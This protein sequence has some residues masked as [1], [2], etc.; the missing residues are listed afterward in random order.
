MNPKR[1][2]HIFRDCSGLQKTGEEKFRQYKI[3]KAD[4]KVL[5]LSWCQLSKSERSV[6]GVTEM[7]SS[8]LHNCSPCKLG[9]L[10]LWSQCQL[11][12]WK[13]CYN[14]KKNRPH[15]MGQSVSRSFPGRV[16]IENAEWAFLSQL[17]L[18]NWMALG[19]VPTFV[20][21]NLPVNGRYISILCTIQKKKTQ[22]TVVFTKYIDRKTAQFQRC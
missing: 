6:Q 3:L 17:P 10:K 2:T 9:P 16:T 4:S 11:L 15:L 14:F 1:I 20:K 19:K 13:E 7:A 21:F 5:S 8:L 18:I 22:L 12:Q